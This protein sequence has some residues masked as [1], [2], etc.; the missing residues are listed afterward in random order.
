VPHA[1][2]AEHDRGLSVQTFALSADDEFHTDCQTHS[3]A[4]ISHARCD[5]EAAADV[6]LLRM[7]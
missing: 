5:V 4:Q 7:N 2:D 1:A 6:R 3:V